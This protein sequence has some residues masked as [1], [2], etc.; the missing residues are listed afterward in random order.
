MELWDMHHVRRIDDSGFIDSLYSAQPNPRSA[1]QAKDPE[2]KKEQ[3]K[4]KEE[5]IAKIKAC[6]HPMGDACGC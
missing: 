4:K 6:G 5:V 2:F 3:A 1:A